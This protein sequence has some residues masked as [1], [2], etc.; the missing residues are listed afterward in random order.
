MGGEGV[1]AVGRGGVWRIEYTALYRKQL[2][3]REE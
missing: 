1:S 3:G 2:F